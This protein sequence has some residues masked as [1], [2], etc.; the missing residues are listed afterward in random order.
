MAVLMI[1]SQ[2]LLTGFV[3]YWLISQ[4]RQMKLELH[5]NLKHAYLSTHEQLVDTLLIHHLIAPTLYDSV[6]ISV[7]INQKK[8]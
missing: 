3:S 4:Y 8:K 7:N 2:L 1:S 5:T 6:I